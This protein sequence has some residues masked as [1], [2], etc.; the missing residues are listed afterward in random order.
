VASSSTS[1]RG[2][3]KSQAV[4]RGG[5][6]SFG[7]CG[8]F[9]YLGGLMVTAD[10]RDERASPLALGGWARLESAQRNRLGYPG[11]RLYT[12][13]PTAGTSGAPAPSPP[14]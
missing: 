2:K 9:P 3:P 14:R 11:P 5:S 10:R 7:E 12:R 4:A 1:G 13:Y 8:Y 6:A